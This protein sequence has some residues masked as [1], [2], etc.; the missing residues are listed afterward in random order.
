M[1]SS[2]TLDTID[3]ICVRLRS[4]PD[5]QHITHSISTNFQWNFCPISIAMKDFFGGKNV[6][7]PSQSRS[8]IRPRN[9]EPC[10]EGGQEQTKEMQPEQRRGSLTSFMMNLGSKSER[11]DSLLLPATT[12]LTNGLVAEIPLRRRLRPRRAVGAWPVCIRVTKILLSCRLID[13]G[14][15]PKRNPSA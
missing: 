6:S 9:T 14:R 13:V 3:M 11:C 8:S 15:S 7:R 10:V 2:S 4:C 1:T 12:L 5:R